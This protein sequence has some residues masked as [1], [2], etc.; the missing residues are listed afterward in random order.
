[1]YALASEGVAP[2]QCDFIILI[3]ISFYELF[4]ITPHDKSYHATDMS[5]K[6]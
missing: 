2:S 5:I 6:N 1:M 3:I 4:D